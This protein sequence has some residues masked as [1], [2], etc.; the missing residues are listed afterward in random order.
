MIKSVEILE[1]LLH[2]DKL[3]KPISVLL[4]RDNIDIIGKK[5]EEQ[6][7]KWIS[8]NPVT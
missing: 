1:C 8:G 7:F 2:F 4:T 6:G 3:T 5:L